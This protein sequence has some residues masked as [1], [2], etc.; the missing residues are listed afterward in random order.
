LLNDTIQ[1]ISFCD[2]GAGSLTAL[3]GRGAAARRREPTS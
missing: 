2:F 1:T 3:W